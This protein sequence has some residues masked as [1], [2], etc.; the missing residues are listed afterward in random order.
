MNQ[1]QTNAIGMFKQYFLDF[2]VLRDNP[3]E[4]WA[5]QAIN[6]LDNVAYW[7]FMNIAVVFLSGTLGWDD[8]G[9]GY[10]FTA[11]SM[12][13]TIALFF[14]GFVTDAIGI[15]KALLI[16]MVLLFVGRG[17]IAVCGLWT[18]MPW[19]DWAAVPFFLLCSPGIAMTLTIYQAANR[20]FSS[21]RSRSASFNLWYLMMNLGA[22][23]SGYSIDF[24]RL[25]LGLADA[26]IYAFAAATSILSFVVALLFIHRQEQVVGEGEAPEE[27]STSTERKAPWRIFRELIAEKAFWRFMVLM[28]SV[29]GVRAVF[30]YFPML[31]PKYW[32][33]VIGPDVE[34][35]FLQSIN[36][37]IIIVGVVLTIPIAHRF[38]VFKVLV[39]GATIAAFSLFVLVLPW[40]WFGPDPATGYVRMTILM[41]TVNSLGELLWSPKLSEYTAAIAPKGQE[42]SYF[43]L[44]MMPWFFAKLVVSSLSGHMLARWCPEDIGSRLL[45]GV[46]FWQSPEAMWL[47]LFIWA[48]VGPVVA[49]VLHRWLTQGADLDPA[50]PT[51]AT[52]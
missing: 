22:M 28:V 21:R 41:A 4:F 20:R 12:L 16:C 30:L 37:T 44:S 46:P 10:I 49:I 33:R 6:F 42:G 29:L 9:A 15:R 17:G 47:V 11:F 5:V 31:M 50:K 3:R 52:A 45:E 39:S 7:S 19:R 43:G 8:V 18:T 38:N 51:P 23:L 48:L 25:Q 32:M 36:P 1:A 35:G 26:W 40:S 34:M 2:G 14:T 27:V 24:I 13:V